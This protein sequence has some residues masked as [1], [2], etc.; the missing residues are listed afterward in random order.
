MGQEGTGQ[1]G[2]PACGGVWV[3]KCSM[4]SNLLAIEHFCPVPGVPEYYIPPPSNKITSC[5]ATSRLKF[6]L[7]N[8]QKSVCRARK[9]PL[10]SPE[11]RHLD[12][13]QGKAPLSGSP[14]SGAV[15]DPRRKNFRWGQNEHA[16]WGKGAIARKQM[17]SR[18]FK[19]LSCSLARIATPERTQTC[20]SIYGRG[21][22]A[23]IRQMA[24]FRGL[25]R[26]TRAASDAADCRKTPR[27]VLAR[28]LCLPP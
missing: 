16:L 24:A 6:S 5:L 15:W 21:F 14:Q 3:R 11:R 17:K 9:R 28:A 7:D 10:L 22:D 4:A 19:R 20:V 23:V 8:L 26:G 2:G 25:L 12:E 13:E 27:G 18:S 1:S